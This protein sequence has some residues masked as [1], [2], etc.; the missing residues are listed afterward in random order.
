MLSLSEANRENGTW[1][2]IPD[3]RILTIH[4][5]YRPEPTGV[6]IYSSEFCEW[7]ASRG[8]IVY[9]VCPPP[10]YPWW[11]VQQ[12]YRSWQYKTEKLGGVHVYRCPV[13]IPYRPSGWRRVAYALSFAISSLPSLLLCALHRPSA[14]LVVEPSLLNSLAALIIAKLCHSISWLHIQDCEVDIAF[15]AQRFE[16]PG[17]LRS[18]ALSFESRLLR[19]FDVVS[20]ISS[21]M[22]ERVRAKGVDPQRLLLFP[23][24]VDT[25]RIYPKNSRFREELGIGPHMV[26]ALFSGSMGAKQ[27]VEL[28]IDAA[29]LLVSHEQ[30]CIVIC[31]DDRALEKLHRYSI[32]LP[33]IILIPLQPPENV[34]E[35]LNVADIHLL[36]QNPEFA[37]LVMPSKLLGMM[38]SGRPAVATAH[39]DSELGRCVSG[40]GLVVEPN[41]PAAIKDAIVYLAGN[42]AARK[43]LGKAGR[44]YAVSYLDKARILEQTERLLRERLQLRS[45]RL[46]TTQSPSI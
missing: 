30:I 2:G 42:P 8:Y 17:W 20:T 19:H 40:R 9:S 6:A 34:N 15:D 32:G 44:E 18:V 11:R 25:N 7:L 23:N 33:N 16:R 13:W 12:P 45:A 29:R 4:M 3:P 1:V 10:Y 37:D 38:A 41:N 39:Q 14:V 28:L 21:R 22:L 35:L 43:C 27:N 24:W 5:F 46:G 26:V 36:P 31:G